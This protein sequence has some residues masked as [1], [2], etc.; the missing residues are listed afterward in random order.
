[1]VVHLACREIADDEWLTQI[2]SQKRNGSFTF[3][4]APRPFKDPV[5]E[6]LSWLCGRLDPDAARI[7][8][9]SGTGA[10]VGMTR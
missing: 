7:A 1:M 6:A 9:F 10:V 8:P 3:H 4:D 5:E 2:G